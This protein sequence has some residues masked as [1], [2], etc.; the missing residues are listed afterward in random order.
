[1]PQGEFFWQKPSGAAVTGSFRDLLNQR[2]EKVQYLKPPA[3]RS[4]SVETYVLGTGFRGTTADNGHD[5]NA[6]PR[7]GYS[8]I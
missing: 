4:E 1:M 7:T 3:S 6:E 5:T 2:F 8:P